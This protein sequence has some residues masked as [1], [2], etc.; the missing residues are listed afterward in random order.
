M[1]RKY[2]RSY[3]TKMIKVL[4]LVLVG[5]IILTIAIVALIDEVRDGSTLAYDT[6]VLRAVN[7]QSTP[8]LDVFMRAVT[9]FGSIGVA[10][11]A[12][13]GAIFFT[14]K[15]HTYRALFLALA[16]G[17]AAIIS[18]VLKLVFERPRPD[19]W[20]QLITEASFAFP[21]GHAM[22]SSSLALSAVFLFW[23]TAYRWWVVVAATAYTLIIGISR[24]YLGVHY[25]TDV[26]AGWLMST[27]WVSLVGLVMWH[28]RAV[29]R[30][31]H[32]ATK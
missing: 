26:L 14:V 28:R 5:F 10:A 27:A 31:L 25:P 29:R 6:A 3:P 1:M 16:V 2:F 21:S 19:L 15:R 7:A 30:A 32:D 9:D 20:E 8:A 17:G 12:V 4:G 23:G 24:L 18:L 22:A 11:V 13:I